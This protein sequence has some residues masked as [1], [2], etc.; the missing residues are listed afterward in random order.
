MLKKYGV[1]IFTTH[2]LPTLGLVRIGYTDF[3]GILEKQ[4]FKA[5]KSLNVD[6]SPTIMWSKCFSLSRRTRV[7]NQEGPTSYL[8]VKSGHFRDLP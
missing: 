4:G 8:W 2:L 1:E 6:I 5:R 3:G 7:A